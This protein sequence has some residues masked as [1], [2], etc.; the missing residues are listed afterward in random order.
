MENDARA[1]A[2][3]LEAQRLQRRKMRSA[4]SFAVEILSIE[5]EV[6]NV[7]RVP[8][9]VV[10]GIDD[11]LSTH[12]IALS[13]FRD[14]TLVAKYYPVCGRRRWRISRLGTR[15]S[16]VTGSIGREVMVCLIR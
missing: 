3:S 14:D 11:S 6:L 16:A 10:Q 12:V 15:L 13:R 7:R 1:D 2:Q 4:S 5:S 8:E 9:D